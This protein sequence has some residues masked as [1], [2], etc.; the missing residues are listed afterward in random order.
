[1]NFQEQKKTYKLR[2]DVVIELVQDSD[3]NVRVRFA[4][5]SNVASIK[6]HNPLIAALGFPTEPTEALEDCGQAEEL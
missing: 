1:M 3:G 5:G 4:M 6:I 2:G